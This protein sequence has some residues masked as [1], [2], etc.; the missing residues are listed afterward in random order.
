M[1]D[2][3]DALIDSIALTRRR[4][5]DLIEAQDENSDEGNEALL[6]QA[7]SALD[8]LENTVENVVP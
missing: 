1:T 5:A 6:E 2:H 7:T 8:D 3:I 4:L